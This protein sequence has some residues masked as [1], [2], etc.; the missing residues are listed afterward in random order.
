MTSLVLT[1]LILQC[2]HAM[3]LL[4]GIPK[5]WHIAINFG[6]TTIYTST[7]SVSG[8]L[9]A[10]RHTINRTSAAYSR[11]TPRTH[12]VQAFLFLSTNVNTLD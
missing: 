12:G 6:A 5:P 8:I 4:Q 1:G 11:H 7:D 9:S 2:F 10:Q 3:Y